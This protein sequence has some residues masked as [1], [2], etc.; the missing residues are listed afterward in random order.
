MAS[1]RGLQLIT[2]LDPSIAEV[3]LVDAMRLRQ[4]LHNLLSNAIKFTE[5]GGIYFS[6]TV[7]ADDHAGQLIEFRV[8]DTG[9]GMTDAEI[10][11]ALQ[12]F[13]QVLKANGVLNN[14]IDC[15]S[16][17]GLAISKKLIAT[18]GGHLHFDSA[19]KMGSAIYFSS[20]FPRTTQSAHIN[21]Y[22]AIELP[23]ARCFTNSK[24]QIIH[25]LLVED[26]PASREILS[27]QLQALGIEVTV[28]AN[29]KNA[30]AHF[31]KTHFDL[32]FTDH[33]MPGMKGEELAYLL[34]R[35]SYQDL[36]II[37]VTADIYA[38]EARQRFL[39]AGMNAVL[40]KPIS[41]H[42]LENQ[43]AAYFQSEKN[44]VA[45]QL[46]P[47][48][49][50]FPLGV[51][52][53]HHSSTELLI[54]AEVLKVQQD[55]LCT[56]DKETVDHTEL[57]HYLHKIKGGALLINEPTFVEACAVLEH[58]LQLGAPNISQKLQ[59]LLRQ[60]NRLIESIGITVAQSS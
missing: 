31:Q 17:L 32:V 7:L 26:H 52:N 29:G 13:E 20:V 25:A 19:P 11:R 44:I 42:T 5:E 10:N 41:I 55:C 4:I 51:K 1:K 28:C 53:G 46:K 30:L 6:V 43:L 16:G 40:I 47:I 27:L 12:P 38:L 57:A 22:S 18:M 39:S 58:E 9:I 35:Q 8:V 50:F 3:L 14:D 23:N 33:S 54:L 36:I 21:N 60:K 48:K 34:R 49:S 2:C 59:L 24:G 56:L 37:G 15:G 45:Q